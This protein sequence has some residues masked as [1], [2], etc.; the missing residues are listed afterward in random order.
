MSVHEGHMRRALELAQRAEGETHPNPM[1]GAVLVKD[2]CV[3]GEGWHRRAGGP[4]A[5][6]ECLAAATDSPRGATM[7]VTLEPCCHHGRTPP[8]SQAL[9]EAGVAEVYYAVADPNPRVDGGGH[10]Q[11]SQAGIRVTLGPCEPEARALNRDFFTYITQGR[12]Y[13]VAKY[14]MSL[15]GKIATAAGESK[16]ITGPVARQWGHRLRALSDA[17]VVGMNTVRSDNPQLTTR[18]EGRPEA[19]QPLRIVLDSRGS[20]PLEAQV[21]NQLPGETVLATTVVASASRQAD[22]ADRPVTL[23]PLAADERGRPDV[24]LLLRRLAA[25][26]QIM[27]L[28]V[29]G[30]GQVLAS[31]LEAGLV[32]EVW[33]F[34][35]A[36]LIGGHAAP[37]PFGGH[38]LPILDQAPRLQIE[39]VVQ[40]DGDILLRAI[41][42]AER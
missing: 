36:R 2:G 33:A 3:I 18:L 25:E 13:V 22:L 41:V 6:I 12:P 26:R 23:M 21:F 29:E 19:R 42:L 40:L 14:A 11:L 9:I 34:V 35:G 1:V 27:R 20:L 15:D 39:E 30:G 7:Y 24:T 4:H 32:D 8:C 37:G 28:M 10:S 16:W 31:F 17:I 38:G 5:E